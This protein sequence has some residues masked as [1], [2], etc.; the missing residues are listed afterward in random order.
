MDEQDYRLLDEG[1]II[2]PALIFYK[3]YIEENIQTAIHTLTKQPD[4]MFSM[5]NGK[6]RPLMFVIIMEMKI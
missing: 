2:T 4:N 6:Q 3:D 5:L 1:Q